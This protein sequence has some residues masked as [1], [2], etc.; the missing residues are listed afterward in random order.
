MYV[1]GDYVNINDKVPVKLLFLKVMSRGNIRYIIEQNYSIEHFLSVL[2]S[3]QYDTEFF[4][5]LGTVNS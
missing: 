5:P 2:L 3:T 4:V 1:N